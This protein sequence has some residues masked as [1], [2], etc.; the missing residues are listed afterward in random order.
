MRGGGKTPLRRLLSTKLTP[1]ARFLL[2]E[3]QPPLTPTGKDPCLRLFPGDDFVWILPIFFKPPVE[4]VQLLLGDGHFVGIGESPSQSSTA[5]AN[6]SAVSFFSSGIV[7]LIISTRLLY[8][9]PSRNWWKASRSGALSYFR[10]FR[11]V[12]KGSRSY[13]PRYRIER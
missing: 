8:S 4:F 12:S 11:D 2:R 5:K 1:I 13:C 10:Q 9:G 6:L 3:G 7:S